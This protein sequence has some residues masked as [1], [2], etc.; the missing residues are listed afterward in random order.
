M[1]FFSKLFLRQSAATNTDL[2]KTEYDVLYKMQ[3][4]LEEEVRELCVQMNMPVP[5]PMF[6]PC[7]S[8]REGSTKRLYTENGI[9]KLQELISLHK[10]L[11]A[12]A[13]KSQTGNAAP[14]L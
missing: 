1:G 8:L 3:C 4:R 14:N 11:T 10:T 13:P 12:I 6:P 2:G 9:T 5:R 7:Y